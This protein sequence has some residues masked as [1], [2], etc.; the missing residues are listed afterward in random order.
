MYTQSNCIQCS[1]ILTQERGRTYQSLHQNASK[2]PSLLYL[3]A[4]KNTLGVP[5]HQYCFFP[6]L[7]TA[8]QASISTTRRHASLCS[9]VGAD[10]LTA[11]N[12]SDLRVSGLDFC[13]GEWILQKDPV[14]TWCIM[15]NG[16]FHVPLLP[17]FVS[18]NKRLQPWK[19]PPSALPWETPP[20]TAATVKSRLAGTWPVLVNTWIRRT[21]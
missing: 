12:C 19:P 16:V 2:V 4:C 9:F 1:N 13:Q 8:H 6:L 15:L 5:L 18:E 14:K 10:R 20:T 21:E 17:Q 11:H 7:C 3:W